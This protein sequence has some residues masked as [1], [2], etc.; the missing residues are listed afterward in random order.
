MFCLPRH[1]LQ[2]FLFLQKLLQKLLLIFVTFI[3]FHK[4]FCEKQKQ[5][6]R[7]IFAKISK[8]ENFCFN[9]NATAPSSQNQPFNFLA[10]KTKNQFCTKEAI[11]LTI[12]DKFCMADF[13]S[14]VLVLDFR[15]KGHSHK[16]SF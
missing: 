3:T 15:Y 16:N 2:K 6:L 4:L 1:F 8:H 7:E 13:F 9:L 10:Q 5:I 12:V 11:F 14:L